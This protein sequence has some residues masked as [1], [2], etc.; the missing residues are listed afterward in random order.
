[1]TPGRMTMRR[2]REPELGRVGL[3]V[4]VVGTVVAPLAHLI[5]HRDD[6][7][8]GPGGITEHIG[9]GDD[10][11]CAH[12]QPEQEPP[13]R[14][15]RAFMH[16]SELAERDREDHA[17]REHA[18]AHARCD[19]GSETGP[20]ATDQASG[21]VPNSPMPTA[22]RK[23]PAPHGDG[24]LEHFGV[25]LLASVQLYFLPRERAPLIPLSVQPILA[26]VP[27]ERWQLRSCSPRAPPV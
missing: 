6:H 8:H 7:R 12:A 2:L 13:S 1:M 18:A 11:D 15:H 16:P 21:P 23:A 22:P 26:D 20:D 9:D 3:L 10:D 14:A 19:S 25:A 24:A 27:T 17:A 4:F 5:G